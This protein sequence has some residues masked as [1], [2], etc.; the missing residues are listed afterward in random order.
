MGDGITQKLN[1]PRRFLEALRLREVAT[2]EMQRAMSNQRLRQSLHYQNKHTS[3]G[4]QMDNYVSFSRGAQ[5]RARRMSQARRHGPGT[6]LCRENAANFVSLRESCVVTQMGEYERSRVPDS[7]CAPASPVARNGGD[8]AVARRDYLGSLGD[9][10]TND[11]NELQDFPTT[12]PQPFVGRILLGSPFPSPPRI[13][14][15]GAWIFF[16]RESLRSY[17]SSP[18]H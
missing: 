12:P 13:P 11:I 4:V 5:E 10:A 14:L 7:Q 8:P 18:Y 17:P 6:A 3:G 15:P 1:L 2:G 16:R 9:N